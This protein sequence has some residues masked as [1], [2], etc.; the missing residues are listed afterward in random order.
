MLKEK[1]GFGDERIPIGFGQFKK[2]LIVKEPTI[3]KEVLVGIVREV[4]RE[5]RVRVGLMELEGFEA[6][7]KIG[8]LEEKAKEEIAEKKEERV[9][10]AA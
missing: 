2:E 3:F 9:L 6:E 7:R 5:N 4:E 1:Y 8:V 10:L